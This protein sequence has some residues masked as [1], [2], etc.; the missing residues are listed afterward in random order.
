MLIE[1]SELSRFV[2]EEH[3]SRY[4]E[5][6]FHFSFGKNS[7]QTLDFLDVF[8]WEPD[9]ENPMTTFSTMGMS[10]KKFFEK[11]YRSEIHWTIRGF[12]EEKIKQRITEFL[13]KLAEW[14]FLK[15]IH[16]DYWHILPNLNI[17]GFPNSSAILFHPALHEGGW[18]HSHFGGEQIRILNII[19]ITES[20]FQ[21]AQTLGVRGMLNYL[22][23]SKTDIFSDRP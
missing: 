20:E 7:L 11:D 9:Q 12:V 8:V 2:F 14:P 13:V 3:V 4:G 15:N 1:P 22:Y 5:P 21:M 18:D 19:P 10:E 6:D 17:P 23:E 16:F